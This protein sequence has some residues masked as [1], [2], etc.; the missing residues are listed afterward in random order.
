M[1]ALISRLI[2][3]GHSHGQLPSDATSGRRR[4][5]VASYTVAPDERSV[6]KYFKQVVLAV[7]APPS[8]VGKT[9]CHNSLTIGCPTLDVGRIATLDDRAHHG[10]ATFTVSKTSQLSPDQFGRALDELIELVTRGK[11]YVKIARK[12]GGALRDNRNIAQVSPVFWLASLTS[13]TVVAQLNAFKLFD[14]NSSTVTIPHLLEQAEGLRHK[15]VKADPS[16][17][18][19]IVSCARGQIAGALTDALKKINFKRHNLIAHFNRR[20]V[21]DPEQLS[22]KLEVTFSDLGIVLQIA[23][24]ILQELSERFRGKTPSY[25]VPGENDFERLLDVTSA[26]LPK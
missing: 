15:F 23:S 20:I 10:V 26:G 4:L 1:S 18:D 11:S 24:G 9:D 3:E 5:L 21:T 13:L 7:H 14:A 22:K 2:C 25:E 12:L 16:E 8:W 17:V 19:A 6:W